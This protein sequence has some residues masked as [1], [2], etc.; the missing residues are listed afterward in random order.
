MEMNKLQQLL[1]LND[2]LLNEMPDYKSQG[3]K[4]PKTILEQRRL[5][6]SLMNV[7]PPKKL[8]KDFLKVQDIFLRSEVIEK[9]IV[10]LEDLKPIKEGSQLYLW[11]GDI[12]TL[13]VDAIV[14]AG[15]S[16][17]LGCFIPCHGCIDNAIHSIAGLQLRNDCEEIIKNQGQEEKTG[18]A[19]ITKGYN[20][21]SKF[22]I[23]TVGP[24]ITGALSERDC[25]LLKSCYKS[26]LNLAISKNLKSIAFCCISTGEFHFPNDDAAKIAITTVREL[27]KEE[28][29]DIK[30]IF[31]VF[32]D[33]DFA[34]YKKYLKE[35]PKP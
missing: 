15:N 25:S 30:V 18:D 4:F 13:K 31:N 28:E 7:R 5:L 12:T 16:A 26:S 6:R 3:E 20:L 19:K 32:K 21:P 17:L 34:L 23:H 1:Y 9:G 22:V 27:L 24:I 8:S 11:Q 29:K 14:N 2:I 33:E 35:L 10:S